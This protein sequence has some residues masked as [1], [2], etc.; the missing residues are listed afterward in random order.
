M[1]ES[2]LVPCNLMAWPRIRD[3]LPDQKLLVYHLWSTCQQ[4]SGCQ[5][6]DLAAFQGALSI[7]SPAVQEALTEF[8]RRGLVEIDEQTGEVFIKDWFRFHKF[9][10]PSRR[11]AAEDSIRRIQ[12]PRLRSIVEESA[13]YALREGKVREG[14][15]SKDKN[16]TPPTPRPQAGGVEP[17]GAGSGEG[18]SIELEQAIQDE[19]QGRREAVA[20]GEAK[21]VADQAAWLAALRKRAAAGEYIITDHG[22]R[23]RVRREAEARHQAALEAPPE[24]DA[25]TAGKGQALWA[26]A[27][28][29]R[30]KA[31]EAAT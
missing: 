23:V 18:V 20:R 3:L 6:V 25:H 9:D 31:A 21:P 26:R 19:L 7:T 8:Q 22:Q 11:R 10:S 29:Q 27:R 15:V 30:A 12:S 24:M 14:K 17:A 1:A 28:A 13:T 5:L 2:R 4:V 16:P